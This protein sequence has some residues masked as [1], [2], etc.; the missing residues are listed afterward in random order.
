M[1]A[2]ESGGTA[3]GGLHRPFPGR[4]RWW[5]RP[6]PP[7]G[8]GGVPL[9][10]GV[11]VAPP[12]VAATPGGSPAAATAS[13][14]AAASALSTVAA[15]LPSSEAVRARLGSVWADARPWSEFFAASAFSSPSPGEVAERL[16]ENGRTY[17]MNYLT[18]L[19]V[20]GALTLLASPLSLL[21]GGAVAAAY[22]WLFVVHAGVKVRVGGVEWGKE[23]KAVAMTVGG[24]GG[25]MGDRRRRDG[26]VLGG[27]HAIMRKLP[28]EADFESGYIPA[29]V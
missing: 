14:A 15:L 5:G 20:L 23:A 17:A 10:P 19:L 12:S 13:A 3:N 11:P 18:L 4:R 6:P 28:G 29:T 22:W 1:A 2:L 21:G 26:A 25:A 9:P 8:V 7:A 27:A 24:G 16:T